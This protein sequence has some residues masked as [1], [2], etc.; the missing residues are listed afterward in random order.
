MA[1]KK[2]RKRTWLRTLLLFLLVPLTVWFVAFLLWFYWYDRNNLFAPDSARRV[3]PK[4]AR[5][6]EKNDNRGGSPAPE[7]QEKLFDE[8]RKKLEDILKRRS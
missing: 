3:D 7:P 6:S 1:G 5:Q 4:P 2:Q 8:D